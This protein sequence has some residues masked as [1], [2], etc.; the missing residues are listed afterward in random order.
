MSRIRRFGTIALALGVAVGLLVV[1]ATRGAEPIVAAQATSTPY[2]EGFPSPAASPEAMLPTVYPLPAPQDLAT[3][4]MM[5]AGGA[6]MIQ[7]AEGMAGAAQ[8]MLASDV[9][10]VIDRGQH[11]AEDARALRERGAWMVLS[12]T[13]ESMV[14]DPDKAHELNLQNLRGNGL[15]MA[16]EGRAMS[17][18]GKEMAAEVEQLRQDG[19]LSDD[20]SGQLTADAQA[21]VD[22][23]DALARDGERMRDYAEKLLQSIGQ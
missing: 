13:A 7:A 18:H 22:T 5:T 11:W 15:S 10:E 21:L 6:A 12:S 23:G 2:H 19:L 9:Q 1:G 8:T 16:A 20:L 3:A 14:H 17:E 4:D